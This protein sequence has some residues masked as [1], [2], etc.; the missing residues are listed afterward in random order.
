MSILREGLDV[1]QCG[2]RLAQVINHPAGSDDCTGDG[3][4]AIITE[5][6][7]AIGAQWV[8]AMEPEAPFGFGARQ[9]EERNQHIA[10]GMV[11]I[12]KAG[13]AVE[14][15]VA[16]RLVGKPVQLGGPDKAAHDR[17][18]DVDVLDIAVADPWEE[19]R[20]ALRKSEAVE[21]ADA[22]VVVELAGG[23]R[24]AGG[25]EGL[26]RV[27]GKA[28]LAEAPVQDGIG[29]QHARRTPKELQAV[30]GP[31]GV[32][33][34]R[35]VRLLGDT[36]VDAQAARRAVFEHDLG[37]FG[38]DGRQQAVIALVVAM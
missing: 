32:A 19:R 9:A 21:H 8:D 34:E 28:P 30:F 23:D 10:S 13:V 15:A 33:E 37:V 3:S 31:I 22:R 25:V 1:N 17:F 38:T 4:Y 26:L 14:R 27:V 20:Q 29:C 16:A 6:G 2:T 12:L 7:T 36:E 24:G 5:P 18:V 35:H 11:D